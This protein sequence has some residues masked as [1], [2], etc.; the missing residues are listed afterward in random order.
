[1]I[2]NRQILQTRLFPQT[3]MEPD[4]I[5]MW[6]TVDVKGYCAHRLT[7][8]MCLNGIR[9]SVQEDGKDIRIW[10]GLIKKGYRRIAARFEEMDIAS[11]DDR[12]PVDILTELK[13][14][15]I[16]EMGRRYDELDSLLI[17]YLSGSS[18]SNTSIIQ[19]IEASQGLVERMRVLGDEFSRNGRYIQYRITKPN[20]N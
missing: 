4:E 14:T 16:P 18:E 20:R 10:L 1:M 2:P 6:R 11:L 15:V 8:E 3:T 9:R 12:F 17:G 5:E 7:L 13:D 19:N